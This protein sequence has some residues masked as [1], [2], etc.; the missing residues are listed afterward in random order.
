MRQGENNVRQG[1]KQCAARRKHC[2]VR[3]KTMYDKVKTLC[4]VE[5]NYAHREYQDKPVT[6]NYYKMC[7]DKKR[8]ETNAFFVTLVKFQL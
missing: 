8:E 3:K 2:T 1:K 5:K 7:N 4:S 6:T